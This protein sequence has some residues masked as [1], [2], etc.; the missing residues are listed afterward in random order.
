MLQETQNSLEMVGIFVDTSSS[1]S[2]QSTLWKYNGDDYLSKC[3]SDYN[4]LYF[5]L[6]TM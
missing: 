6:I 5:I 4:K 1:G 2:I 3:A